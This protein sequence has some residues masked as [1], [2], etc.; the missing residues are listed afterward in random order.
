MRGRGRKLRNAI[1]T[2]LAGVFAGGLIAIF[3]LTIH[4]QSAR[5]GRPNTARGY[6]V[7][8]CDRR[9]DCVY[10]TGAEQTGLTVLLWVVALGFLIFVILAPV[11][12]RGGKIYFID[13]V[14]VW[15]QL[16]SIFVSTVALYNIVPKIGAF[17]VSRGCVLLSVFSACAPL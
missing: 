1:G 2:L 5:P 15:A 11:T 13:D 14:Q 3:C 10:I 7:P 6:V 8:F 4:Y 9:H 16:L 12:Y 17:I